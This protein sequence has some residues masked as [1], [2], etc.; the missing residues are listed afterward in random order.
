MHRFLSA[1][2]AMVII[3][4]L[5]VLGAFILVRVVVTRE[6]ELLGQQAVVAEEAVQAALLQARSEND[7]RM[8]RNYLIAPDAGVLAEVQAS[9]EQFDQTLL[10]MTRTRRDSKEQVLL[11]A[12]HQ[13]S[14]SVRAVSQNLIERRQRGE[15]VEQLQREL[16]TRHQLARQELDKA[17]L[18][19]VL[20]RRDELAAT[21]LQSHERIAGSV[22][23]F[24]FGVPLALGALLVLAVLVG[25]EVR[26]KHAAQQAAERNAAA[27]EKLLA[28]QRSTER[29]LRLSETRFAGII[30]MAADAIISVNVEQRITLFNAGAEAIFGYS[31]SEVIGQPLDILMPE[32]FRGRHHEVL[33]AFGQGAP[34]SRKMGARQVLFG[35]R[36]NG[37]E[38]PAEAAISKLE[39]AGKVVLTVIFRDITPQKQVEAEH[40][41]LARAGEALSSSLDP[42]RT[43]ASVAQLAVQSLAD[44][45]IVYLMEGEQVRRL[46][47]A[48]RSPGQQELA[49]ALRDF[50]FDMSRPFLAREV[51]L[52][53]TPVLT[54][55]VTADVLASLSQDDEHLALLRRL[56]PRSLMGLPLMSGERL[57]GALVFISTSAGR[58]YGPANL[59]FARG[60]ARLASLAMENARLYQSAQRATSVRD[61]VLGIVAHDLRSPLSSIAMWLQVVE[62]LVQRQGG[63]E[64]KA[65]SK[66]PLEMISSACQRMNR[67][68]QDLLD[69]ARMEAGRLTL[70]P[71]WQTPASLLREAVDS[72]HAQATQLQLHL[73]SPEALPPVLAD[74]DRLL[75]VFSNLL[76]NALKF[77][78]PGGEIWVGAR[79]EGEQVRFHVRDSGPGIPPESLA[80]IFDRFWQ[81]NRTDRRGAG[82]G[83]SIVKGIV[84]AHGGKLQVESEPGRGSTFSF[85]V[86][87]GGGGS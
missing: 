50:R 28:E 58:T 73:E 66:E 77:T 53:R 22:Q 37:E 12:I 80:H 32:R 61:E 85:T 79:L 82:L 34:I 20:Q 26:G 57:I 74:R 21:H 47:V 51:L 19:L 18:A 2:T 69:V 63:G 13:A 45:C 81:A 23:V 35:L 1:T 4:L 17:I 38:F 67:L 16:M 39:V 31:A 87:H 60:L 10:R 46:E 40:R 71:S 70:S 56:G 6:R 27:L 62:R 49:Q 83:L 30:A 44:W 14:V 59:E 11:E 15:P 43:L 64:L 76:G 42:E 86:P 41:F 3:P 33:R 75:Q 84:E 24:L 7:A 9:R 29:A 55:H 48:H 72:A 54:P 78:P 65:K 36:R 8:V 52:R 5:L 25:R 68:I